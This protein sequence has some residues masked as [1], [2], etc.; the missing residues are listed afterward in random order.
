[1]SVICH[2]GFSLLVLPAYRFSIQIGDCL[3][4]YFHL[5]V[6]SDISS[7]GSW[8]SFQRVIHIL[9]IFILFDGYH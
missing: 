3:I 4:L 1:M 8:Y 2:A 6:C 7:L 9:Y 5:P